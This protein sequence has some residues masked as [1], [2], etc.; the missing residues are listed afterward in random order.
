VCAVAGA[1]ALVAATAGVAVSAPSSSHSL[2]GSVPS[3]ATATHRVGSV[4]ASQSVTFRVYLNNR[5]G[6]AAAAY[7]RA[8]STPGN[9]L[10]GKFL[11]TAQYRARFSPS[12]SDVN[13]V[14]S[15]L[16]SQG[17]RVTGVPSNRK[18]VEATGTLAQASKTFATSFAEYSTQGRT[19]RS[20][21]SPLQVPSKLTQVQAVVGLDESQ[22]LVRPNKPTPPPPVFRNA[23]PCSTYWGQKTVDNTATP[24]GTELPDSPTA[25]A[26][27]GYSGAQLQGLY[28]MTDAIAAGNDGSGVTVGIIDAYASPTIESDAN[29][30]FS[31]HGIPTFTKGQFRQYAAPGTSQHPENPAHDP[32]GWAGEETLDVEAVHTMAPGAN[33]AYIGAPNNYR[34]MDAI[35][36]K[37]VSKHLADIVSNSYGYAGESLPP[38][39][40][41][42]QVDTQIQAAAEGISLFFSSGDSGDET[43]GVAGATPTPDWPASS[44]WVTAVGGTSAGVSKTN[45][46]VFE[47][48]W[49]TTKSTL[50]STTP[51]TWSDPAYLYGS[52]GG[53]SRLFAQPSYQAG[54][55]PASIANTYGGPA[56]RAVPDVA[57]LG[58]PNTGMLVGETQR[59]PD[60]HDA[61]SEYRIGG[62]SLASPLYA[63]IFALAV[64]KAGH[65]FGLANPTLYATAGAQSIDITKAERD[66]Y[67]GD[68]RSDFVN[69]VDA[70]DGYVYSARWF[71]RDESLTI[72]VRP[73]Y[74]DV[75][76]IGVPDGEAWLD[77]VAGD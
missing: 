22:T 50:N 75:T 52:G 59:F 27:C 25:F 66:A 37:V 60:G 77:A 74:D 18:Y 72:H 62:T 29:T 16:Q 10:Y 76:G 68:V 6:A 45:S 23:G 47:L 57:A 71:D 1:A 34:D 42:P 13:T 24:D 53:T 41:K 31:R 54:V 58:D 38:G 19:V 21:T 26:P 9:A 5:G 69:G 15:W 63:C 36:N 35:M 43:F 67:P 12:Q 7:A 49:E 3:W 44:P 20:N 11:T 73:G 39:Y 30:Y 51:P 32:E 28:G 17:F 56:M 61:Y 55:V 48:G 70:S 8:V 2:P 14:S 4:S 33:I 46:R 64:Q 40:I 65:N